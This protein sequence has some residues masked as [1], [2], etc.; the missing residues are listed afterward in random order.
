MQTSLRSK[1]IMLVLSSPS[2]AGKSSLA[3]KLVS[4]SE[5]IVLSTSVTTRPIRPGEVEGQDYYFVTKEKFES[6]VRE[7][8]F[9]EWA[10][11]FDNLYGTPKDKVEESLNKV[12]DMVFDIDW[13]GARTLK[14]RMP[15]DIVSIYILP[16]SM[17]E[18]R[19]RLVNRSQDSIEVIESRMQKAYLEA[20]HYTEYDYVIINDNFDESLLKLKSILNAEHLKRHRQINLDRFVKGL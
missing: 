13:Q 16:P 12:Q 9:L 6:M 19:N 2:G 18:L 1:G 11:V 14:Q 7:G 4:T 17:E 15:D 20:S 3:R 5:N 10:T 8:K